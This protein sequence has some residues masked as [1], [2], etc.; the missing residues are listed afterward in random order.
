MTMTDDVVF[1]IQHAR[2]FLVDSDAEFA[3]GERMQAS[4]KLWGA[5]SQAVIALAASQG[6]TCGTHRSMKNIVIELDNEVQM[7]RFIAAEKFHKNFYHDNMEDFE[8][9]ADR[10]FVHRFVHAVLAMVERG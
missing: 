4:E 5:A 2:K 10:P 9:E 6:K 8:I 7:G 3:A 1:H